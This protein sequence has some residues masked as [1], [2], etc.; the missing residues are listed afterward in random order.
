MEVVVVFPC[1]PA[2]AI[3]YFR[4]AISANISMRGI[5]GMPLVLAAITSGF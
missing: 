3:V 5:T 1:V 4:R 2:T